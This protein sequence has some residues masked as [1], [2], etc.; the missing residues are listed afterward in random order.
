MATWLPVTEREGLP[1]LIID[2]GID[3]DLI[4][5]RPHE[6]VTWGTVDGVP[7]R[8]QSAVTAPGPHA[9]WWDDHGPVGPE[10]VF[11]LGK[12]DAF[13]GGGVFT[14]LNDGSHLG[15]SIDFFGSHPAIVSWVGIVSDDV[16]RI[17]VRLEDGDV[18]PIE[19][20]DG[21]GGFPD[22]FWFFPPRGAAGVVVALGAD[23]SELQRD[24]LVDVDVPPNANSG[25]SINSPGYPA[26][27]PPPGWLDD[28][29]IYGPGEGPRH[30]EGFHL[31]E[32]TFPIH[33][34]P[35]DRWDGHAGLSG[36]GSFGREV[37][38][39]SFGYFD[40]PG[41]SRRGFEVVNAR[42]DRRTRARPV[43][44][45]DVGIWWR[46]RIPDD[47]VDN[48]A[49]RFV[50]YEDRADLGGGYGLLDVGPTRITEIGELEV[51]GHRVESHRRE[52]RRLS[53]LRSMGF[54]LPGTRVTLLGWGLSFDEL[55]GHARALERLELG[56][57][58]FA[59]MEAAQ[60]RSDRRFDELHGRHHRGD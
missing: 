56:T 39:V 31:Y 7:W 42:P 53:S 21:P 17:E 28:P 51:A 57:E 11:M 27:Q 20:H 18:R 8:I 54:G 15:A 6:L 25:T 23:G 36:S 34:V 1:P 55:E 46:D 60:A 16:A 13:G 40:E 33:V 2:E 50:G 30:A 26:D 3:A 4:S 29:T 58:L 9:R 49:S 52:Y 44:Q 59:A 38:K 22:L 37:T 12:D 10:L 47:D 19:V 35:P 24:R 48:F 43:R 32:T 5:T 41:G 45:E 14:R